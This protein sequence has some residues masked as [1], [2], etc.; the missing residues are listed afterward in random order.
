S[1]DVLSGGRLTVGIGV[2]YIAAELAALGATLADRGAMT[3]EHVA[4]M[5][6]LWAQ[7]DEPFDGRWASFAGVLQSPPPV[8]RPAP[9]IVVGGHA[10][11]ALRRAATIGDG[12][13][14]WGLDVGATT[15]ALAALR[16]ACD[17][18][19]RD[20]ATLEITITPP[21]RCERS[22][23]ERYAAAG[24]HRLVLQPGSFTGDEIDDVIEHAA[25]ELIGAS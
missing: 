9:P 25:A 3:D 23:L 14:G 7:R 18:V 16:R 17:E 11:A 12:W 8:Q 22:E 13:F 6:A 10:P 15:A 1:I 19:G 4:A 5:R 20:P 24:V 2:G 21:G